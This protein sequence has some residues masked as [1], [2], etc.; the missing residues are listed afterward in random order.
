ME[1]AQDSRSIKDCQKHE[2]SQ[3]PMCE[4]IRKDHSYCFSNYDRD[5]G[6]TCQRFFDCFSSSSK[7][8]ITLDY[9]YHCGPFLNK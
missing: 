7:N 8:R 9:D 1:F 3:L 5:N 6:A 4:R 2:N